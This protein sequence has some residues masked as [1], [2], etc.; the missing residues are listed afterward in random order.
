VANGDGLRTFAWLAGFAV[1]AIVGVIVHESSPDTF[2]GWTPGAWAIA[3]ALLPYSWLHREEA[4]AKNVVIFIA[5][6]LFA[7]P[8]IPWWIACPLAVSVGLTWL[9]RSNDRSS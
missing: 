1:G 7:L 2:S 8:W 4:A 3:G 6:L 5:A 9:I